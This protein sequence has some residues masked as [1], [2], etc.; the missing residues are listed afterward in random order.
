VIIPPRKCSSEGVSG[1]EAASVSPDFYRIFYRIGRQAAVGRQGHRAAGS[2]TQ[3]LC[4]AHHGT[5]APVAVLPPRSDLEI[6]GITG[7]G[8][9]DEGWLTQLGWWRWEC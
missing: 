7:V 2:N 1:S 9:S 5:P 8:P 6:Q 4:L 3:W